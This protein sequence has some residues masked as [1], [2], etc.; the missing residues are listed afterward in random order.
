MADMRSL[1]SLLCFPLLL[2]VAGCGTAPERRL[3]APAMQVTGLTSSG[4]GYVLALRLINP[5][6]AP[7]VVTR[8]THTLSLGDQRIGRFD[9]REPIGIPPLGS[10]SH[11]V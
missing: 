10:E 4:G 5:N 3:D 11:S 7:L 8:S 9:D 6:P 1:F 2:I